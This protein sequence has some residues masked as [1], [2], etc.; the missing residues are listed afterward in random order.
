MN[1][2]MTAAGSFLKESMRKDLVKSCANC[3]WSKHWI[4]AIAVL[5]DDL[6]E[7]AASVQQAAQPGMPL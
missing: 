1:G 3:F 6:L 5:R 4:Q 2:S 7:A